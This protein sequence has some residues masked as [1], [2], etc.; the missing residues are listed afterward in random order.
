MDFSTVE[1][2]IKLMKLKERVENRA[3]IVS[4][5][6]DDLDTGGEVKN[7]TYLEET[8]WDISLIIDILLE[9]E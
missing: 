7:A 4:S 5:Y 1:N 8:L 2:K 6:T 3:S 9:A